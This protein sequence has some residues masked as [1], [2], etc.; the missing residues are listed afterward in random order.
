MLLYQCCFSLFVLLVNITFSFGQQIATDTARASSFL[1][2]DSLV[3][4]GYQKI[5]SR[6]NSNSIAALGYS[7]FNPGIVS[8]PDQLFHGKATGVWV[9][10][11]SGELGANSTVMIR[12]SLSILSGSGPVVI[13][14]GFPLDDQEVQPVTASSSLGS[15]PSKSNLIFLNPSDIS[16]ITILKD[17]AATSIY[18]IRGGN[19]VI[20][21]DTKGTELSTKG[22][23]R[24]SSYV[25]YSESAGRFDLLDPNT[26]LAGVKK[27]N[28]AAGADPNVIDQVISQPPINFGA[29]T[30]WQEKVVKPTFSNGYNLSWSKKINQTAVRISGGYEDQNG[31]VKNTGLGRL[32]GTIFFSQLLFQEK[33]SLKVNTSLAHLNNSYAPISNNAG[34]QGSLINSMVYYNPTAPV[35]T[36]SGAFFDKNDGSRNPMAMLGYFSDSDN[37]FRS[38][39]MVNA[40]YSLR[41]DLTLSASYGASRFSSIRKS[42]ADPRIPA[43]WSLGTSTVFGVNYNNPVTGMGRSV[44]QH[45]NKSSDL[46]DLSL[47]FVKRYKNSQLN[48]LAGYS[49]QDFSMESYGDIAWGLKNPVVAPNDAFVK[50]ISQFITVAPA[51][52]PMESQ[53]SVRSAYLRAIFDVAQ[54]YVFSSS[55]R[56]DQS[57]KLADGMVGF[58]PS[59]SAKWRIVSEPF[60]TTTIA[61]HFSEFSLRASWGISGNQES[62]DP[63][64]AADLSYTFVPF[65]S[66][67]PQTVLIHQGNPNLKWETI[68]SYTLGLDWKLKNHWVGGSLD[69]FRS[70]RTDLLAFVPYGG[71]FSGGGYFYSNL[72][73]QIAV[74]GLD[75]C[76]EAMILKRKNIAWNASA[77]AIV[78]K[79][80]VSNMDRPISTG[81]VDGGGL[82]AAYAQS[83]TNGQPAFA[84]NVATF[85]G[86]DSN[87]FSTYDAGGNSQFNGNSIPAFTGGIFNQIQFREFCFGFLFTFSRSFYI[88]NNTANAN[89]LAA[90]LLMGRNV[91]GNVLKS[92][93]N[94]SNPAVSSSRFLESG[95]NLRLAN[96]QLRYTRRFV[97]MS[98]KSFSIEFSGQNLL[99]FTGYS[100]LDPE[101]NVDKSL[102][103]ARSLGF[104]Y[105][106]YPRPRSFVLSCNFGF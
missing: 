59:L 56:V 13:L 71:G 46:I 66:S 10:S 8:T 73:G 34:F 82:T 45:V 30:N 90:S 72:P 16:S 91:T 42:F 85:R 39:S 20:L 47:S 106:G 36:G 83:I 31:I 44:Y 15:I 92:D 103:N 69:Y 88:Y 38:I 57:S 75:G 89:L 63:R 25:G 51:Y 77:N 48:I 100:G 21:I 68:A 43:A 61:K 52:V 22:S 96:V 26:F 24:F 67:N 5:S 93:E 101:V 98:I 76:V 60:S 4:I 12:G 79:N 9:S 41:S 32:T 78:Q 28:L 65:R 58:F 3:N 6:G 2:N 27:A 104:D 40:V 64:A 102:N 80:L 105:V 49:L 62:L 14:D 99:L 50:D 95:D 54:R 94:P 7:D 74:E 37:S 97:S 1:S 70:T 53:Y 11:A 87:G 29:N 84:W 17:A 23:V 33:L 35:Y 86:F 55:V 18:G 19:G 81:T